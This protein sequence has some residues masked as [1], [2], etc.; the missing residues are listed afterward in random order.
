MSELRDSL[1][2]QRAPQ[3]MKAMKRNS[4]GVFASILVCSSVNE[5]LSGR[6]FSLDKADAT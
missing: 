6:L 1:E 2:V 5:M 4:S 3:I